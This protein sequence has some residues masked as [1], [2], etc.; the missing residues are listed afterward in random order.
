MNQVFWQA[1]IWGLLHDPVLKAL[2]GNY[3]R[4]KQ[5][6]WQDLQVM[7]GWQDPAEGAQ[8]DLRKHILKADYITSASDR[9]AVGSL[10]ASIDY[11]PNGLEISHLLSGAKQAWRL[12]DQ[13][14]Q[15]A[16]ALRPS[17]RTEYFLAIERSLLPEAIKQCQNPRLV[18]WWLW[19]CLPEKVCQ[20]FQS[21]S[22]LL[23]PAETRIPDG[24]IWS[25]GSLTAAM[26]GALAGCDLTESDVI[27]Q[28]RSN[29]ELSRPY[30]AAFTFSPVQELIK[31]SRK[32]RDFWAGSWIL[33]Y[34][35]AKVCWALAW[36]Y[37]PDSLL[38]P[39]LYAQPLIDYWL[40]DAIR[41]EPESRDWLIPEP[42]PR[43][44]LTAGFPNVIVIIL[45]KRRVASAMQYAEQTLKEEWHHLGNLSF[46]YIRKSYPDWMSGLDRDSE[47]WS[48]WLNAQWQTYWSAV[49]IGDPH[50]EL[51]SSELY[52]TPKGERDEWTKAQNRFY[53]LSDT[54]AM[55]LDDELKFLI[56]AGELRRKE[57][58][59]NPFSA[60]VGSW[61]CHIFDCLRRN[62][63][64]VKSARNWEIPTAFGVRSTISGIGSAVHPTPKMDEGSIKSC[65]SK[66]AGLFDGVE[67]LNATETTKRVLHR[68][69]PQLFPDALSDNQEWIDAAYPDLTAGVAGFLKTAS[70]QVR[71]RYIQSWQWIIE[72]FPI[73]EE[74]IHQMQGNWGI[75]YAD[76]HLHLQRYHSRLLNAGWLV[77]DLDITDEEKREIKLEIEKQINQLYPTNNPTDWYVLA[78]GDGDRMQSWLKGELLE[79]YGRYVPQQLQ[80]KLRQATQ[81]ATG[82]LAELRHEV[83]QD[84]EQFLC[85]KKRMGPSTHAA[86]S[87]ALLDFSNQLLPYLTEQRY[88][89]RL[90]YGG[91]DDLLA[92]TNLWEWDKW[93]WDVRQCFRG[94]P[95]PKGEFVNYGDYWHFQGEP[96]ANLAKRPLFTMGSNATI[97]FG[98]VIANHSV[99]LAIALENMWQAEEEAKEH[100]YIDLQGEIRTKDAVQVR[101]IYGNGNILKA[102]YK[103]DA[104]A[105]WQTLLD[106]PD[107]EPA[108]FEQAATLWEQHPAP[109][110]KAI[111]SWCT[112]FCDRR[113][114]L[115]SNNRDQFQR[116]LTGF[117]Q[118]LWTT[119][120][121]HDRDCEVQNWL[122]LA[123]FTLR[124]RNITI[125]L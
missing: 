67:M 59:R 115:A 24:S 2:H 73:V 91:G 107:L 109:L 102:T 8:N 86:L 69:L 18:F 60:N 84:F 19:R 83:Q 98:I 122:K 124:N 9:A 48:G 39:S 121:E 94:Q 95:D 89:G 55:F 33:H 35:S 42:T 45:P 13:H 50:Q 76:E 32:M 79:S 74:V 113:E 119:T 61:W 114:N 105:Q 62:L 53:S 36:K 100:E 12:T 16:M 49:A 6:F 22:L 93:L 125:N 3:G 71:E 78:A 46:T 41:N 34:L 15:R 40:R 123:A 68:I 25:H 72:K 75:P 118:S 20:I 96:L 17:E 70:P 63:Q 87:R 77:E 28:R 5:S 101:V 23:M 10:T 117:I 88:A 57:Q 30:L 110:Y 120:S 7:Q 47:T 51:A 26:A 85:Q 103:F 43:Q 54:K 64:A 106:I 97:S 1:K 11:D 27:T 104:F 66:R 21:D 99:P 65:W 116:A 92:Y 112:V 58:S 108:L 29:T 14:H 56:S 4:G 52:K 90:I 44:L 31:A 80:E 37:G 82:E 111:N 81:I 38:Y